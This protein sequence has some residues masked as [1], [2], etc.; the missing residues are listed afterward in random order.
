M[1]QFLFLLKELNLVN[2]DLSPAKILDVLGSNDPGVSDGE[3][4]YNLELE[5]TFLEFF[6]ALVGCA[7]AFVTESVVKD[8]TTPRPSTGMTQDPSMYSVPA[9][10]SRM[11]SQGGIEEAAESLGKQTPFQGSGS[12][13]PPSPGRNASSAALT[14]KTGGEESNK[15]S[16]NPG[17]L[18]AKSS[19]P[20]SV[21]QDLPG[22]EM[23][24]S[25]SFVSGQTGSEDQ[26]PNL[27]QSSVSML[28]PDGQPV[29][30]EDG[31]DGGQLPG[32][33]EEVEL[34]DEATRKFNFWTHQIHIFFVRKFFPSAEKYVQMKK[35][36]EAKR[37]Q[38]ARHRLS[39]SSCKKE[40]Q[41]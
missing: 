15:G 25:A 20:N 39:A 7:E 28:G 4:C 11:T 22:G 9:S 40:A 17:D 21:R 38:E 26:Q 5:M 19:Q 37:V 27:V 18:T 3:G 2:S 1:R 23:Q 14:N 34:I 13:A 12:P 6:E 29:E 10:P 24:K 33:E 30:A 32:E 36:L 41:G 16:N 8:P 35:A 31:L